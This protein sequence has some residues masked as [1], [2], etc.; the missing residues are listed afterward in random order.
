MDLILSIIMFGSSQEKR[1][2]QCDVTMMKCGLSVSSS[3]VTSNKPT[4]RAL[5]FVQAGWIGTTRVTPGGLEQVHSSA[6]C[7]KGCETYASAA[8]HLPGPGP[9][10]QISPLALSSWLKNR[11]RKY[12][13]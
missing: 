11:A 3:V 1:V 8:A 9:E 12:L 10:M 5:V 2:R 7:E 6:R 13:G 4:G